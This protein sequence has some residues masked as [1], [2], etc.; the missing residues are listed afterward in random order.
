VDEKV[1]PAETERSGGQDARALIVLLV[2]TLLALW[3]V[4]NVAPDVA[5]GL[6]GHD[7]RT[8]WFP[9][10]SFGFGNFSEGEVP[11]W[12]PYI[13]CGTPFLGSFQS[14]LF[15]PPNLLFAIMPVAKAAR[16]SIV[17]HVWLSMVFTY[18]L[19]R[20]FC[21][22]R[23]AAFIGAAAFGLSAAVI[24][25]VPA[26][27][28]GV[29]CAVAWLPL[30]ILCV[31]RTMRKPGLPYVLLGA[32]AVALQIYSGVPQIVFITAIA[33]GVYGLMRGFGEGLGWLERA[34][35][36]GAVVGFFLLGAGLSGPQLIPGIEAALNGARSLPM[37][38][39]WIEQ[40]SLGPENLVTMVLPGFF[41]GLKNGFYWGRFFYWEMNMYVGVA[42][43][44]LA[45]TG[46]VMARPQ[47]RAVRF[48]LLAA[49][50]LL[51][52]LGRHTPL[53]QLL[54]ALPFGEML[55]GPAKFIL[56]MSLAVSVLAAMGADAALKPGRATDLLIVLAGLAA[57]VVVAGV[58]TRAWLSAWQMKLYGAKECLYALGAAGTKAELM[59]ITISAVQS[60][61]MLAGAAA[62]LL[63]FRRNKE[64]LPVMAALVVCADGVLFS[65]GFIGPWATFDASVSAWPKGAAKA[66]RD[67]GPDFRTLVSGIP[68]MDDA[69]IERVPVIEG[70][71]PNPPARL[72]ILF[73]RGQGEPVDIAPSIYQALGPAPE[74]MRMGLG[75]VLVPRG[76]ITP[77]NVVRPLWSNGRWELVQLPGAVPRARVVY[78]SVQAESQFDAY[79]KL[80]KTVPYNTV[81]L[82]EAAPPP[83]SGSPAKQTSA[84]IVEDAPDRVVVSAELEKPG[85]LVLLDNHYP[86]WRA[87]ARLFS[88]SGE[89][90][91]TAT[92]VPIVRADFAFRAVPLP[93]GTHE[94][95]FTYEPASL[96]WGCASAALSFLACAALIITA[97]R[98]APPSAK[99]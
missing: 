42:A 7:A 30:I 39:A 90:T 28:W 2:L 15:Y 34:Q 92:P 56:P 10:R 24:L 49:A 41:G 95:V 54:T 9:W 74:F 79:E 60:L 55:R 53:M 3:P 13:L 81:V 40:F 78:Q 23:T 20:M 87:T 71:E 38:R 65:W 76:V 19:A 62:A 72:H 64:A 94:V 8:Q 51:L 14:A 37:N 31:E 21:G 22:G 85:W 43:L 59:P 75:R 84:K 47:R 66:I 11:L 4:L 97:R 98:R 61:A 26:G 50:M 91:T 77:S 6:P 33:A 52:A 82:E 63:L 48:A 67:A 1:E 68:A 83:Q 17:L 16:A 18:L 12:N 46:L 45:V 70:I 29:S 88:D 32:V 58:C 69:M 27:H 93:A 73:R 99:A 96:K 57:V 89:I 36:W 25:R 35:R 44:A 86:G 80:M 5:P